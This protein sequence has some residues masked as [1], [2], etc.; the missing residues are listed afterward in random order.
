MAGM[1]KKGSG[2]ITVSRELNKPPGSVMSKPGPGEGGGKAMTDKGS[3][4][5]TVDRTV[6]KPPTHGPAK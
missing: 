2:I 4:F 1:A 6:K 3:G 5:I